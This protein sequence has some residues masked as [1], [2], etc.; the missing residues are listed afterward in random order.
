MITQGTPVYTKKLN[1]KKPIVLNPKVTSLLCTMYELRQENLNAFM[2]IMNTS[3]NA[4][5]TNPILV[6][7]YASHGSLRDVIADE[8][9]QMDWPFK[10]SLMIDLAKVCVLMLSSLFNLGETNN[11]MRIVVTYAELKNIRHS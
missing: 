10:L 1:M 3:V 8:T 6:W 4:L 7:E 5:E 9:I 11:D 2:G